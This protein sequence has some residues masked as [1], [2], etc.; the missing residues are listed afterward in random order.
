M[1]AIEMKNHGYLLLFKGN[2]WW[3]ELDREELEKYVA[4]S[5]AWLGQLLASGKAVGGQGLGR[6]GAIVS[7][8]NGRNITDAPFVEAKEV[9]GG[10]LLLNVETFEEALVIAKTAPN[11][12]HGASIELRPLT[13][14]CPSEARLEE[15]KREEKFAIA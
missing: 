6:G 13:N 11:L 5:N 12:A 14:E 7:G 4:A 1:N 8:K 15:L 2:E 9:V 3:R 10:Y